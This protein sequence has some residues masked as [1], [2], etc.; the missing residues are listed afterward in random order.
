M[1]A[2]TLRSALLSSCALRRLAS[3]SA[4]RAPRLAQPKGFARARR[5]YP[6]AFAAS[7]MSTS[8]GAKEAPANNPGLQAEVDPATKGYF[9]QQTLEK[10]INANSTE[11]DWERSF[12]LNLVAHTSY[13]VTVALCSISNLRNRADKSK[14]LPPIYKVSKT[15]YASPSRVN[16]RLDQR[17]AVETV[18]AYPNIYFSIDDFD[19]PFDAVVLSDPEHCYCVILNAHDG[20]AF[21]EE[22]ES[23]NVGSNIQS[24]I[25]SGSSGEN[26]PK[27]HS[28]PK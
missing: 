25:N 16:F 19:D 2:A 18:P 22:S 1:A 8:S 6:A 23:S 11:V 9:M 3:A 10:L 15:V 17:K 4:P 14:R 28:L 20:A 12:Y 26:P 21:P 24:G 27:V 7:A 13:T 5:S